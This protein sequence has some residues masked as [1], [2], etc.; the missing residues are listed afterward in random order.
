MTEFDKYVEYLRK[1]G[2]SATLIDRAKIGFDFYTKIANETIDD[3]FVCDSLTKDVEQRFTSVWFFNA[4][5]IMECHDFVTKQ[6]FDMSPLK[7]IN[8]LSVLPVD[9]DFEIPLEES[10]LTINFSFADSVS[11]SLFGTK[12]NCMYLQKIFTKYLL[13]NIRF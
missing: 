13:P 7:K 9:Y 5:H 3:I 12:I 2:L 8:H 4:T 11:G 10:R 6:D 1:I